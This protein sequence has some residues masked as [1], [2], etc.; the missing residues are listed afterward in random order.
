MFLVVI[1]TNFKGRILSYSGN[2]GFVP[3]PSCEH[4]LLLLGALFVQVLT[5]ILEHY[6]KVL[7]FVH[8][9]PQGIKSPRGQYKISPDLTV[10]FIRNLCIY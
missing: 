10:I 5:Q 3:F 6:W 4:E 7:I 9:E 8:M 1:V 2:G